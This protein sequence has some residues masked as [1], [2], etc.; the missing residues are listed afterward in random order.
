MIAAGEETVPALRDDGAPSARSTSSQTTAEQRVACAGVDDP[1]EDARSL[2]SFCDTS[3]LVSKSGDEPVADVRVPPSSSR[4]RANPSHP[5][6]TAALRQDSRS[7]R[8]NLRTQRKRKRKHKDKRRDWDADGVRFRAPRPSLVYVLVNSSGRPYVG[9]TA[10]CAHQLVLDHN[11]GSR[12]ST[13]GR[14]PWTMALS[15][16]PFRNPTAASRFETLV[17]VKGSS[18][19][20]DSKFAAAEAA[21]HSSPDLMLEDGIRVT[22]A[23]SP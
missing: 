18:K 4:A 21:L 5:A 6:S 11:K 12:R 2:A 13:R 10:K 8:S 3:N 15:I 7:S 9:S 17:K 19:G 22:R 23:S 1:D 14:G 16:G 20:L